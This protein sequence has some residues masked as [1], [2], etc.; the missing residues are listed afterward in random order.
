MIL[1][2]M[3]NAHRAV[4]EIL[5]AVGTHVT[6]TPLK[7]QI[8]ISIINF[9]LYMDVTLLRRIPCH[10]VSTSSVAVSLFIYR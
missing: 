10:H 5:P 3:Y 6:V 7:Y 9:A 4:F 2:C 8:I 1:F